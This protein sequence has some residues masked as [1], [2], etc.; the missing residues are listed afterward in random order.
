MQA[1]VPCV[2][3]AW[4]VVFMGR[5]SSK[6]VA[7]WF[8]ALLVL[9]APVQHALADPA[10]KTNT[11]CDTG[12]CTWSVAVNNTEVLN[13]LYGANADGSVFVPAQ[14]TSF[15]GDGAFAA[16]NSL[17]GNLDPIL[18]FSLSA[19]TGAVGKTFSFAFSMP[20]DLS[21]P[22][23]A[24]S[25]VSYSLTSLSAAG[26]QITPL[27]GK[28]VVAQEVDTSIGGL[29]P[30]NKGVDVGGL[31]SFTGGPLTNNSPVYTASNSFVGSLQ[32]D[33]MSIVVSF[34]LSPFSQVGI[35]GFV[36]QVSAV[37]E[38]GSLALMVVGVM[39]LA[40]VRRK[41]SQQHQA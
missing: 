15:S 25:S 22:I 29:A 24:N 12:L 10:S 33:L 18:G 7:G 23:D 14:Q 11:T 32:Y 19:S 16:V 41:R 39:A 40:L 2:V 26:A 37:P 27:F 9:C 21:G 38:P 30:L 34:A 8:A 35:S 6:K 13:G 36:Q 4:G 3:I 5:S 31:F 20:I 17:S 1:E 28:L